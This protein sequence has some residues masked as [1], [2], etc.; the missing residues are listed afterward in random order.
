[1]EDK[2]DGEVIEED[3]MDTTKSAHGMLADRD[4]NEGTRA[5]YSHRC[6][7]CCKPDHAAV[8]IPPT[9]CKQKRPSRFLLPCG[10]KPHTA[11]E[12]GESMKTYSGLYLNAALTAIAILLAILVLRPAGSPSSVQA[13][14]DDSHLYIEPGT[15]TLRSPDGSG[16]VLGKVVIDRRSGDVWGFPTSTTAPYPVVVTSHEPPVSKPM[17][18]GKFD[19]TAMK[20]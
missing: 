20:R 14:S 17:Y 3:E 13:Q 18:L 16:Q 11:M 15:T 9:P 4:R 2:A 8:D 5:F 19:F 10:A 1:M 6:P 7:I 12:K